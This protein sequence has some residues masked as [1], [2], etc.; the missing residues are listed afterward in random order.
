[1]LIG[2]AGVATLTTSTS[3]QWIA[4]LGSLISEMTIGKTVL[5]SWLKLAAAEVVHKICCVSTKNWP[6]H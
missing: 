6:C 2:N 4:S 1:L 5:A 3:V